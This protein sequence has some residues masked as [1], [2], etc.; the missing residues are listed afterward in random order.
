LAKSNFPFN[1]TPLLYEVNLFNATSGQNLQSPTVIT[2]RY[3]GDKFSVPP[4]FTVIDTAHRIVFKGLSAPD[5]ALA[6]AVLNRPDRIRLVWV[7]Q[8][9]FPPVTFAGCCRN[10]PETRMFLKTGRTNNIDVY[11]NVN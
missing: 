6:A 9:P 4:P 1:Q 2:L 10:A 11:E 7:F 5:R 8:V 3:P